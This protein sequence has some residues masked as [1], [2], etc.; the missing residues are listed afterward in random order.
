MLLAYLTCGSLF[1]LSFILVSNAINIHSLANRWM[2]IFFLFAGFAM[3]SF[4][5]E[6]SP[7]RDQYPLLIPLLE[8]TRFAMAPALYFSIL[9]F[10]QPT[11]VVNRKH[12][13][14]FIPALIFIV[15]L[16]G[17]SRYLP[18]QAGLLVM[19]GIKLQLA[20]YWIAGFRIVLASQYRST[21]LKQLMITVGVMIAVYLSSPWIGPITN[22]GINSVL[23][24]LGAGMATFLL[25]RQ[26][27]I[28]QIPVTVPRLNDKQLTSYKA[29]LE[30]L[31]KEQAPYT[32]PDL[33]LPGLAEHLEISVHELSYLLNA[34]L[35]KNFYQYI[36]QYRVAKAKELLSSVTHQHLS[37]LAI[38]FEAGF[39]SK[40]AFNTSF[41]KLT[42]QTP[43]EFR[44]VVVRLD[45]NGH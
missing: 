30:A 34:G 23:Y 31:M 13:L 18:R 44:K 14:H 12:F 45:T 20:L 26:R 5:A 40:T 29:K 1:L 38:G 21:W 24:L 35:E 25:V 43:G 41:K 15:L 8:T 42:G 33:T 11:T 2:G 7:L 19:I 28:Q 39:N 16:A 36:N 27:N 32:D 22:Y 3:L 37:I 9:H 4:V 17:L 6:R 10:T